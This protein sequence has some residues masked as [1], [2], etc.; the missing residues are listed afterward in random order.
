MQ[1]LCPG[2]QDLTD[3]QW[4]E[5]CRREAIIRPLTEQGAVSRQEAAAAAERLGI[6]RTLLYELV[7]RFRRRAQTSSLAPGARGRGSR[8]RAL[9]PRVEAV[10]AWAIKEV[11]LR[12][13]RPRLMDLWRAVQAQCLT[14]GLKA[15][16]YHTVAARVQEWD[17]RVLVRA[18]AGAAAARQRYGRLNPSSLQP[19][20]PLEVVQIDHTALDVLVVD[21]LERQP[22]GRRPWLTL[23]IDVASRLVTGFHVSLERPSSL[24]VALVLTQAVLPKEGWLSDRQLAL[25]WPAAGL[26]EALH[27]DNAAEFKA[28]ALERGTREYGVHLLYRPP[29]RPHFGGHIERLI[30]TMMGAVHLLPG[31]TFS[32]AKEK[33]AYRSEKGAA[34]TLNE[35]ERWLALQ[36]LGVYHQSVHATLGRT[37]AAAWQEG[38]AQRPRPVRQPQDRERFFLDF[39]PG[40]RRRIRRDGVQLFHLHYWHDVLSP[41][42]GRSAKR[43]LIKYDPRNLSRVYWRD[44][45]GQYWKLPYRNLALPP[46]S[47]WEHDEA[48]HRLRAAG[49]RQVDERGLIDVVLQQRQLV[50][51]ARRKTARRRLGRQPRG[52]SPAPQSGGAQGATAAAVAGPQQEEEP[53]GEVPPFAVEV[54]S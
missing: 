49:Q 20:W 24:T 4:Q 42:A 11:Y 34:L 19:G 25:S 50:E 30:G 8:S 53:L 12:P 16:A 39:L 51:Q 1:K 26:P 14:R 46:I 21:E 54:G 38:L 2:W 48:V 18:R 7:A 22:L 29:G 40:Q 37:P 43:V 35:L 33:G 31:T 3:L 6:G 52:R 17:P 41:R 5:A 45:E 13:E 32:D 23:A 44:E 36:I 15:P 9:D 47:L 27:L 28:E 10:V